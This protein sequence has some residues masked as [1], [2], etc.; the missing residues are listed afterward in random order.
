M[1]GVGQQ[2]AGHKQKTELDWGCLC[3]I[4]D[5]FFFFHFY[6]EGRDVIVIR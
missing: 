1:K 6:Q 2:A 5:Q 3:N 4:C